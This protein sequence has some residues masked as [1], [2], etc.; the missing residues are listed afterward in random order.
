MAWGG[1]ID[2]PI[3]RRVLKDE[4]HRPGLPDPNT[5]LAPVKKQRE[6]YESSLANGSRAFPRKGQGN[7][8]KWLADRRLRA[9]FRT[10]FILAV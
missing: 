4:W 7:R 10:G 1:Q 8:H 6:L 2:E 3:E 9:A 5:E